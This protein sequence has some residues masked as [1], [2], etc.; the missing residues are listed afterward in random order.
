MENS[1]S[2]GIVV[3]ARPIPDSRSLI[4]RRAL[5]IRLTL[6]SANSVPLYPPTLRRSCITRSVSADLPRWSTGF[7]GTSA[8]NA[9][10]AWKDF[11]GYSNGV[12][13]FENGTRAGY[14]RFCYAMEAG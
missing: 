3:E 7:G 11:N 13:I 6:V 14:F 2:P 9:E 5:S 12:K 8:E 10:V 4:G 1:A